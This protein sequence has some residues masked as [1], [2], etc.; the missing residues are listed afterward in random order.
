MWQEGLKWKYSEA[1][2]SKLKVLKTQ[3]PIESFQKHKD[4][5]I[6]NPRI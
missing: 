4:W 3:R 6:N 2:G 1:R 5:N